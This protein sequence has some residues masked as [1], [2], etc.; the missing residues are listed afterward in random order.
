M[1]S[2]GSH[3]SKI[4]MGKMIVEGDL[5]SRLDGEESPSPLSSPAL[6]SI[7]PYGSEDRGRVKGIRDW[8][9]KIRSLTKRNEGV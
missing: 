6:G 5:N 9:L 4:I 1:K 3:V 8:N 7:R 2:L